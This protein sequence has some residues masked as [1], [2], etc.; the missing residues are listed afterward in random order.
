MRS[1]GSE[2]SSFKTKEI[3]PRRTYYV[4]V[5]WKRIAE[6]VATKLSSV[7]RFLSS[8]AQLAGCRLTPAVTHLAFKDKLGSQHTHHLPSHQLP[9]SSSINPV[10]SFHDT[11]ILRTPAP[12]TSPRTNQ[13]A[14]LEVQAVHLNPTC[15]F[16]SS[17]IAGLSVP[18]ATTITTT[19][20][21]TITS[22]FFVVP[23]LFWFMF[24][25][26]CV[27]SIGTVLTTNQ[28]LQTHPPKISLAFNA[29]T[30]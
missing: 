18:D 22:S 27:S 9:Q 25:F 17:C 1:P 11:L 7:T 26:C 20:L 6:P 12:V 2:T 19:F 29:K 30:T 28:R 15:T 24:T 23:S 8:F 4:Q 14:L 21:D 16:P 10:L 3:L 13:S 5:D